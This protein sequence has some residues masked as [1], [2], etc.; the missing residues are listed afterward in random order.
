M[1][2]FGA[3]FGGVPMCHGAGGLAAKVHFGARSG[4]APIILGV[5]LVIGALGFSEA[6]I[7]LLRAFPG[8]ILGVMLL[9][10]G[11]QLALG[12]RKYATPDGDRLVPLVTA[13]FAMWNVAGALVA[14]V[15]LNWL[16]RRFSLKL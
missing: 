7:G 11:A 3:T 12:T 13:A 1:N 16:L 4:G 14:G 6:L 5:V 10:A 2:L 8:P 15:V 9:V